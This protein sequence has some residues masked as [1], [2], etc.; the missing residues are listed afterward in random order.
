M[1]TTHIV[2]HITSPDESAIVAAAHREARG[3]RR[4][5]NLET[6]LAVIVFVSVVLLVELSLWLFDVAEWLLPRPS[7]IAEA[8]IDNFSTVI[9]P[10]G[11][12]TVLEVS[13]GFA[14]GTTLGVGLGALISEFRILDKILSPFILLLIT[15]PV[16][17]LVPLLMLWLGYGVETKIAAAA[18]ASFPPIMMNTINGLT[19]TPV[20]QT[21]LMVYMGA[22]R[23]D[24]FRRVKIYNALPSIFTGL[25]IG[26]IFALITTVAAEFVGGSIGL[27][28]RL[29]YYASTLQTP[30]MFAIII[31][32]A[33]IGMTLYLSIAAISRRV[34][35][36]QH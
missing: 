7:R 18:I 28:N 22:T 25:T 12:Y 21:D 29:I 2:E 13:L 5:Q 27:G 30:L 26:S 24:T 6:G 10:H 8:W 32:L 14:I 17:A 33:A 35:S 3:D 23:W 19:R 16:V 31:T 4:R 34:V 11:T 9:L 15:T 20:L 36:W 1:S